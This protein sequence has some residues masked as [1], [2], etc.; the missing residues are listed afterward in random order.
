[1]RQGQKRD[2]G[3]KVQRQLIGRIERG[4]SILS[5]G[6]LQVI[7]DLESNALLERC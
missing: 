3:H 5:F 6:E 2:G 7:D 4:L 1:M